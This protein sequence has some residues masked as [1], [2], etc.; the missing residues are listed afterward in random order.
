MYMHQHM[1]SAYL[2]ILVYECIFGF[3]LEVLRPSQ[4]GR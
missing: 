3:W 2:D 4:V 1:C